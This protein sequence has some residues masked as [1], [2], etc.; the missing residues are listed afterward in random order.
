MP[1]AEF[2]RFVAQ[3][4]EMHARSIRISG[5]TPDYFAAYKVEIVAAEAP[6]MP[7]PPRILDF[8]GGTGNSLGHFR[9]LF[10]HSRIVLADPSGDSLAI[11]EQRHRQA[12]EFVHL[13]DSTLPFE[14]ESFDIA[15]AACVFH[16][17]PASG[18]HAALQE[19]RRVLSAQG[20]LFV[21][22]HNPLNPLTLKAVRDC[23][24]DADAVLIGAGEMA[25]RLR[26]AGFD[27]VE[28]RYRV[29][30]PRMLRALRPL[31]PWLGWL[32][33]GGQYYLR[34]GL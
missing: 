22:E 18:H 2:D 26:A 28:T 24:F 14:E 34:A 33:L 10:P 31:E 25:A 9:R 19:L 3:Y 7:G 16:H 30:F 20:R 15:F 4:E 11:A 8:G 13:T 27:Q 17:I 21:F 23:P 5:E 32:P 12:A 6:R 29:F 1:G